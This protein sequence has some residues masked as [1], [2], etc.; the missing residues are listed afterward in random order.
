MDDGQGLFDA[1]KALLLPGRGG[2]DIL[3]SAELMRRAADQG[4]DE[5]AAYFGFF[6]HLGRGVPQDLVA[7]RAYYSQASAAGIPIAMYDL[8]FMLLHGLGGPI[9]HERG[10]GL[11]QAAA[12]AGE[13]KA[14]RY[15]AI[16]LTDDRETANDPASALVWWEKGVNL[17]DASCAYNLGL[18]NA[19]GHGTKSD[20]VT[21]WSWFKRAERMGSQT[22]CAELVR[23]ESLMSEEEIKRAQ[24]AAA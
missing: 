13:I 21:A 12:E 15:F 4:H 3:K 22:A 1:G 14:I 9:D 19:V 20:L 8:G 10:R 16:L 2:E 11:I 17:G 24:S 23:L 6:L 7:A 5:A 18:A